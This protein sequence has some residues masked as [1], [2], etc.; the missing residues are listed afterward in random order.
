M[1]I[2]HNKVK[3]IAEGNVFE[4]RGGAAVLEIRQHQLVELVV[5]HVENVV[6][7]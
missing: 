7:E 6:R 3:Q 5:E 1:T 2:D 4:E